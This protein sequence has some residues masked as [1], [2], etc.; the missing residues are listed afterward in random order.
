[1]TAKIKIA[2]YTGLVDS[3]LANLPDREREVLQRRNALSDS[4]EAHTLEQIGHD[5]NI[6]RER[7]RQIEGE[8]LKKLAALDY[9]KAKLPISDLQDLISDYLKSH[10]GFMAENHLRDELLS[11]QT[12]DEVRALNFIL[13]NILGA[14]FDRVDD[15]S[16]YQII[17]KLENVKIEQVLDIVSA[18]KEVIENNGNPLHLEDL[19]AKFKDHKHYQ[20]IEQMSGDNTAILEALLR[21]RRDIDKNILEQW[22]LIQWN[23]IK[24]KRMTDKAYLIMLQEG[25]P[26]HFAQVADLINQANFDR[27]KAHP[28]TVHNELI[29]DDKYVLVGRGIYALKEWGYKEGTVADIISQIL[30]ERGPLAKNDLSDEVLKQRLVQKTTITLALMDKDQFSRLADGRYDLVK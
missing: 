30:A 27:K 11:E 22:G 21:L 17:W 23:T 20:T 25:K 15:L 9:E 5:F 16:D 29:L 26:L 10:G 24:P 13:A 28:A 2:S 6:T 4:A 18:L 7:V 19:A 3:L 8:G 1:M 12:D 14:K